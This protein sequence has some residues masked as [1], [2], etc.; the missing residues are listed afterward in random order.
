MIDHLGLEVSDLAR[1][2]A[3]YDAVFHPLGGRRIF[4]A[5]EAIGYGINDA[6]LWIVA[7]GRRPGPGFG[8]VALTASG[9]AA[10]VAAYEAGLAAGG[11]DDGAPGPRH[12]YGP[13]YF[14]AYLLDPDGLR[15]EVVAGSH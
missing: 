8:H 14:S 3:F 15:V 13:R 12:Q 2:A 7:R 6:R 1:S 5:P 4:D 11:R 9:R 10:V